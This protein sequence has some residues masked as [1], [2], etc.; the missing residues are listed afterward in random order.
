MEIALLQLNLP[1]CVARQLLFQV[2]MI[3]GHPTT[4]SSQFCTL[5]RVLLDLYKCI[6]SGAI[7]FVF[8][9]SSYGNLSLF[10]I[11]KGF[12]IIFP[13]MLDAI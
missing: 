4:A 12:T 9:R 13:K 5:S 7:K 6:L 3:Q 2:V 11:K 10:E 8:V 1:S